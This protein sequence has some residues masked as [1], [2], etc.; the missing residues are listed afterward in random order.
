MLQFETKLSINAQPMVG[1]SFRCNLTIYT[2]DPLSPSEYDNAI[3]DAFYR[4]IDEN[5]KR[6]A[7]EFARVLA[8]Q[9]PEWNIIFHLDDERGSSGDAAGRREITLRQHSM[10]GLTVE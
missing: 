4:L 8:E 5:F 9:N 6:I 7:E 10:Y 1:P 3:C 2:P